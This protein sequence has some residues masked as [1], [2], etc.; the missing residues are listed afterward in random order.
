M[1]GTSIPIG[2]PT[3]VAISPKTTTVIT[4]QPRI[5]VLPSLPRSSKAA[6]QTT[7][8]SGS[9]RSNCWPRTKNAKWYRVGI[10][11]RVGDALE[12]EDAAERAGAQ[13]TEPRN[14]AWKSEIEGSGGEHHHPGADAEMD[15]RLSPAAGDN[16]DRDGQG[17]CEQERDGGRKASNGSHV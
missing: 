16:G 1:S 9:T 12:K 11:D 17:D 2:G 3:R 7:M 5:R 6:N 13:G 10:A 8:R 15:D 4:T 14:G